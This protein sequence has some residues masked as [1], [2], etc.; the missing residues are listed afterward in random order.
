MSI[1]IFGN[2]Y[3]NK[4][5]ACLIVFENWSVIKQYKNKLLPY[6]LQYLKFSHLV[7]Y[8]LLYTVWLKTHWRVVSY[9][10]HTLSL[11]FFR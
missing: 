2:C 6:D 4:I 10:E 9:K 7:K 1:L 3:N 5:N 8:L 11:L